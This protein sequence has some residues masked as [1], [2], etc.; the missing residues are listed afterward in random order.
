MAQ[1]MR[2]VIIMFGYYKGRVMMGHT[3]F[4]SSLER[5]F[6]AGV[7]RQHCRLLG[8]T[9]CEISCVSPWYSF[10]ASLHCGRSEP[11]SH[12]LRPYSI[13][14]TILT[15]VLR[16]AYYL[17]QYESTEFRCTISYLLALLTCFRKRVDTNCATKRMP[18]GQ[19]VLCTVLQVQFALQHVLISC[20][21]KLVYEVAG[22][23]EGS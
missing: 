18:R 8:R 9:C 10:A 17:R 20:L 19:I 21:C 3:V 1:E 2:V 11:F 23:R 14:S 15:C 5:S 7:S 22:G 12:S 13:K 4:I 16:A 6:E